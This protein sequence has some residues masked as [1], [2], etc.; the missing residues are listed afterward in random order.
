M[1][2]M[3]TK[4]FKYGKFCFAEGMQVKSSVWVAKRGLY[5]LKYPV[6]LDL[7]SWCLFLFYTTMVKE[8]C[9]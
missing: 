2:I 1:V 7:L 9:K 6:C 4:Y 8:Q 3:A 5:Y